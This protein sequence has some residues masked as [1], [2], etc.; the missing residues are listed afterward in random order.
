MKKANYSLIALLTAAVLVLTVGLYIV[1]NLP[2]DAVY[3]R[4][5]L[6]TAS[7][8]TTANTEEA[9]GPATTAA[10]AG[11]QIN[12]NT[13]TLEELMTLPG[14]GAVYAQRIID[15]REENG[16]YASVTD[17]L[18]VSGIGTKR[19]EAILDYITTGG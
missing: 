11:G 1:R 5:A 4:L 19:L 17:L 16:P 8:E 15:Y 2:G 18:N 13:A 14:I 6:P 7:A 3:M 10:T 9:A 12:I